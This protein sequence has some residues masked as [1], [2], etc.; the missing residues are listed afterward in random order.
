MDETA[1]PEPEETSAGAGGS[2]DPL[3]GVPSL[4][5]Q[6]AIE[7]VIDQD[8]TAA[9]LPL[10]AALASAPS[11]PPAGAVTGAEVLQLASQPSPPPAPP[12]P[13]A[14]AAPPLSRSSSPQ[15]ATR[16]AGR[17]AA[18]RRRSSSGEPPDERPT[19]DERG[20]T[21][22]CR[23]SS[24]P[25]QAL[26]VLLALQRQLD[27]QAAAAAAHETA[28]I[29]RHR[30][31]IGVVQEQGSAISSQLQGGFQAL[32]QMAANSLTAIQNQGIAIQN[33]GDLQLAMASRLM[34][35]QQQQTQTQMQSQPQVQTQ[36][37]PPAQ[38]PA[39]CQPDAAA[40]QSSTPPAA[41]EPTSGAGTL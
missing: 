41:A 4:W 30:E 22:Q 36:T 21:R 7:A 20:A 19:R 32:G 11:P 33:Q 18:D 2:S 26:H 38:P 12:P 8:A 24:E 6:M 14:P 29:G 27:Q 39:A 28:A 31:Q 10:N 35:P 37:Q 40:S 9:T 16:V 25:P 23:S 5:D 3:P 17:P 15:L 13:P 34:Q 1:F